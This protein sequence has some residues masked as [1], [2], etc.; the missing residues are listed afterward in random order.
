MVIEGVDRYRVT[1][2]MFEGVRVVLRALGDEYSPAYI[3]GISGAAFRIAGIRVCAPT[4]SAQM[5]T[6]DLLKLLGYEYTEQYLGD[7]AKAPQLKL[8]TQ[9]MFA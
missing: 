3:Q 4:Y 9:T 2:P 1:E 5:E 6:K 8:N 7:D